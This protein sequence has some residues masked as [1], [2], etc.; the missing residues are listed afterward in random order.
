M[1]NQN[2]NG[3]K[4]WK[5]WLVLIL[6]LLNTGLCFY[7]MGSSFGVLIPT[8]TEELNL[9]TTQIGTIAGAIPLGALIF[10]FISGLLLDKF[11]TKVIMVLTVIA[12][13]LAIILR[14]TSSN[15]TILYAIFVFN[16]IA[17]AQMTPTNN[18]MST[19][20][21]GKKEIFFVTSLLVA[22]QGTFGLLGSI[23]F[24]PLS[25]MLGG[26]RNLY[27]A[28][29][30]IFMVCA[31]L[32]IAFVPSVTAADSALNKGLAMDTEHHTFMKG[33]K[34]VFSSR[35]VWMV[36]LA[37]FFYFGV[38]VNTWMSLAPSVFISKGF[39][40]QTA[41]TICSFLS[42]G[43]IFGYVICPIIS[44]KVGLRKPFLGSA[45]LLSTVFQAIALF[46]PLDSRVL[47]CV[48]I[49]AAGF[50]H[51]WSVAGPSGLLLESKEV[52]GLNAGIAIS[53][54]F[55]FVKLSAVIFPMIY[56]ALVNSGFSLEKA[57]A[58]VCL[59]GLIGGIFILCARETG[60]KAA[61]KAGNK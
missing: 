14:G 8:L 29:G 31:I 18:K 33:V 2:M 5:K 41:A 40:A 34:E 42:T 12:T 46:Y 54:Y 23:T 58:S 22:S 25:E 19:Y 43:S 37:G 38:V 16:G 30:I 45:M 59:S 17:Q 60:P 9:T 61:E 53:F 51:G 35:H 24:L 27:F 6:M 39:D 36:F 44:D 20:W 3:T 7:C 49:T 11:K 1:S 47:T 28:I 56:A 13:G 32:W 48:L 57:L 50:L 15:F 52:G 10:S 26:W 21:F 4:T 55:V